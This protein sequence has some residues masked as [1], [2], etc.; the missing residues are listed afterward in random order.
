MFINGSFH[1]LIQRRKSCRLL[2]TR[3]SHKK[4]FHFWYGGDLSKI[5]SIL[6]H[7][8]LQSKLFSGFEYT[9][10]SAE[11]AHLLNQTL[12]YYPKM[13]SLTLLSY[14]LSKFCVYMNILE[15]NVK[16]A[17]FVWILKNLEL[18]ALNCYLVAS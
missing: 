14:M 12:K 8:S 6:K 10:N 13:H 17:E 9:L 3:T 7:S 18:E 15:V 5:R 2:F 16:M 11:S 1:I 4:I